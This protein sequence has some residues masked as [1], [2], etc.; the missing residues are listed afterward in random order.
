MTAFPPLPYITIFTTYCFPPRRAFC[1]IPRL[2]AVWHGNHGG[3]VLL[4]LCSG[5]R[6]SRLLILDFRLFWLFVMMLL[7]G[8][9]AQGLRRLLGECLGRLFPGME[10][11][12]PD[13]V[14]FA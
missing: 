11:L 2:G 12:L 1:I 14:G 8:L 13:R 4:Y 6:S 5:L 7:C 3:R 10:A 9:H